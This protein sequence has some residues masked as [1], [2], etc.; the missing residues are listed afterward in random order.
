[1]RNLYRKAST[2][3][4]KVP[5]K[6]AEKPGATSPARAVVEP[7]IKP[8]V[9]VEPKASESPK[10]VV[11]PE[12]VKVPPVKVEEKPV[13]SAPSKVEAVAESAP[14]NVSPGKVEIEP[15]AVPQVVKP[16]PKNIPKS[17]GKAPAKKKSPTSAP[18]PVKEHPLLVKARG[19]PQADTLE[20]KLNSADAALW[21]KAAEDHD[22]HVG[23]DFSKVDNRKA[24]R[25]A[26]DALW[27]QFGKFAD[28]VAEI[29]EAKKNLAELLNTD[30]DVDFTP[31]V[32]ESNA[33]DKLFPDAKTKEAKLEDFI[34][35]FQGD[36]E[37]K[38]DAFLDQQ[39]SAQAL[40]ALRG[41]WASV[42]QAKGHFVKHKA[43]TGYATEVAYLTAAKTLTDSA[44][45][46][47]ILTKVR[48]DG[49]TCFFKISTGEFA[50]KSKAGKIRTLFRPG[51]GK[52]YYNNQN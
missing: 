18:V 45:S 9:R 22:E 46:A 51:G 33:Y 8:P 21:E 4:E 30:E 20:S 31:F 23:K 41:D 7:P 6:I 24:A 13:E 44:A 5:T 1:M 11:E 42:S 2:P 38:I 50:I 17:K 29:E 27:A 49:D 15:S 32:D 10:V 26:I 25:D 47:D 28:I 14:G 16:K 3:V 52:T 36:V 37:L 35:D 40:A 39:E 48:A 34:T 12:P 19:Y 43:D